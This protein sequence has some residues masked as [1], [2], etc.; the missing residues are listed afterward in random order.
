MLQNRAKTPVPLYERV[1]Q[2]ILARVESGEWVDGTRLPSEQEF[3]VAF[4]VSRMTVHRALRELFDKG[5]VT[6]VQGVGTF[7]SIPQPRSPL[8]EIRDIAD[9]IAARGH[10]HSARL[11]KL[12]SVPADP[13][14]AAIFDLRKGAKLFHSVIV[15]FEDTVPVQLEERFVTPLFAPHYLDQDFSRLTTTQYLQSIA[16]ATEVAHAVYAIRP[17][18]RTCKL[19]AI[20][21]A[22]ACLRMTRQ[23]WVNSVPAT[24]S[25]FIYPGSRY[26]LDSRYKVSESPTR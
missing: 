21:P 24:K 7:V 10:S 18:S 5:L 8:I 11:V 26:S 19:L 25:I 22:E 9:D 15:R 6:R 2:H 4:G 23:T 20:D 14:L 1:K 17:D 12:E 13:E 3:V 16:S